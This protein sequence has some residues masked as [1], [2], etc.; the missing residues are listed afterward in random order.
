MMLAFVLVVLSLPETL[1]AIAGSVIVCGAWAVTLFPLVRPAEQ[2]LEARRN[3]EED[4][5]PQFSLN[6]ES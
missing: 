3:Q 5:G 6:F 4:A 1:L 2:N